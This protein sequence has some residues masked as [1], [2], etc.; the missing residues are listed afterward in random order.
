MLFGGFL[1]MTLLDFPGSVAC[2]AF[3]Q[4][5]N[6]RCGCCHNPQLIGRR[7]PAGVERSTE[8]QILGFL[9]TRQGLLDGVVVSGGEPTLQPDLLRFLDRVKNLGLLVKLDTNGTNPPVLREAFDRGLLDYVAMDVK[10]VPARYAEITGIAV[11]PGALAESRNLLLSSRAACEFRTTVIPHFHNE[12]AMEDIARFCAGA[13]RFVVQAFR[14]NGAFD[15]AFRA[16]PPPTAGQ[17]QRFQQIAA[18]FVA[19]VELRG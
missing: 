16:Y 3:T 2:V 4:G 15:P 13:P 14:P 12:A 10:N 19:N 9:K 7:A 11:D 1:P 17:L 8:S 5:C 6:L 18:R